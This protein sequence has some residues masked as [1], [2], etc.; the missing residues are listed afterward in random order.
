MA[1]KQRREI[2]KAKQKI[3]TVGDN[4]ALIQ[5]PERASLSRASAVPSI[6]FLG[7]IWEATFT[8]K[9]AESVLVKRPMER[10]DSCGVEPEAGAGG[11]GRHSPLPQVAL[12]GLMVT[13]S[14]PR[15]KRKMY[16][17]DTGKEL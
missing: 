10:G 5:K 14:R 7:W 2:S 17:A 3:N 9:P 6:T 8:G 13:A 4:P 15:P 11:T 12:P 1:Q 16:N